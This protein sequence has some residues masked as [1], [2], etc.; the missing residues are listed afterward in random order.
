MRRE[1]FNCGQHLTGLV[2]SGVK[3]WHRYFYENL[4]GEGGIVHCIGS[5][6]FII[7]WDEDG[8]AKVA[9]WWVEAN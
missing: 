5:G 2:R 7:T 4:Y 8:N 3:M 6:V 9:D 1:R